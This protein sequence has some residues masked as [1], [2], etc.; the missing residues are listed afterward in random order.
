MLALDPVLVNLL[1]LE[2]K[3]NVCGVIKMRSNYFIVVESLHPA[4]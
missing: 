2:T 3:M 1:E 4:Q